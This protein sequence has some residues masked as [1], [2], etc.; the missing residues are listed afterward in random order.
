MLKEI[1]KK[2]EK[3]MNNC[4]ANLE[5]EFVTIRTG[6]ATPALLDSVMVDVYGTLSPIKQVASISIPDAR[7]L[8]IQ[9]WDK[10]TLTAIE[11]GI[12]AAN[13][14]FTPNNDGRVIRITIPTLTEERRKEYVKMAK[15]M[16]EEARIAIRHVRRKHNEELKALEKGHKISEDEMHTD[17]DKIQKMTDEHIKQIDELLKK[18]E[19]EIMEV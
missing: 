15:H 7:T 10:N 14:G 6:R 18:K 8:L 13:I 2:T 12:L 3:E 17:I 9:P 19:E 5:N 11:K 1:F 4:I 16:T